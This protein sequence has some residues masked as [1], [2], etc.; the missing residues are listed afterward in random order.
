MKEVAAR[1][2]ARR[3]ELGLT[4]GQL[5]KLVGVTDQSVS[6]WERGRTLPEMALMPLAKAL[7]CSMEQ[8]MSG[9]DS[10]HVAEN[11]SSPR[12]FDTIKLPNMHQLPVLDSVAADRNPIAL[13]NVKEFV[14]VDSRFD[15]KTHYGLQVKGTSMQNTMLEGDIV[16]VE[17]LLMGMEQFDAESP[18]QKSAWKKLHMEAVVFSVNGGEKQLKRFFLQDAPRKKSG[19]ICYLKGDNPASPL[20]P[21]EKE[22]TLE[23]YGVVKQVIRDPKNIA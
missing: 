8:L 12:Q 20:I 17:K 23:V 5:G 9:E 15:T 14:L 10:G 2:R 21:I 13:G 11:S 18:A 6:D 3:K 7:G 1:I 4:Q 16:I 22:S 19:F